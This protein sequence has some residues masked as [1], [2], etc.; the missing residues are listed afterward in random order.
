MLPRDN[1][2]TR[3]DI[4]SVLDGGKRVT[5]EGV[6]LVYKKTK[7]G[8]L[9]FAVVVSSKTDKRA[10][11]RNRVKRCMREAIRS[12]LQKIPVSFDG[13]FFI[14]RVPDKITTDTCTLLLSGLF[15]K[16]IINQQ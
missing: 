13:V 4:H 16:I 6:T 7:N 15:E 8:T 2:L 1:K 11:K 10:T 9:R 14:K 12:Y 3:K 5:H